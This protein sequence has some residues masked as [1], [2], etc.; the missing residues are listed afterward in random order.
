MC[1]G[2]GR[3]LGDRSAACQ[4]RGAE[5]RHHRRGNLIGLALLGIALLVARSVTRPIERLINAMQK[6]AAG[7]F[8]TIS[9]ASAAQ[10][11]SVGSRRVQSHGF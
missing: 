4:R 6:V 1:G 3:H 11:R 7:D 10:M 8:Q 2:S 9:P 5:P